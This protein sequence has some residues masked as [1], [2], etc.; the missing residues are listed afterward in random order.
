MYKDEILELVRTR[1]LE[2]S[3][4]KVQRLILYG[5]RTIGT[6]S[7]ESNYDSSQ[8]ICMT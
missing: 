2:N 1:V 3:N 5:S 7:K 8:R 4:G 6:A